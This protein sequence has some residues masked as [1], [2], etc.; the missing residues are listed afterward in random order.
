MTAFTVN[1]AYVGS[2][3]N[4]LY[5]LIAQSVTLKR[6]RLNRD[7]TLITSGIW[8]NTVCAVNRGQNKGIWKDD[9]NRIGQILV[10]G[11]GELKHTVCLSNLQVC[12][13]ITVKRGRSE[14]PRVPI[15][16]YF[17]ITCSMWWA[18]FIYRKMETRVQEEW[19][20][21]E[22]FTAWLEKQP[23]YT[24]SN[25]VHA[26]HQGQNIKKWSF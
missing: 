3:G 19:I 6:Y 8:A 1:I 24:Y 11:Y 20:G 7:P 12:F 10:Q 23:L 4:Y 18:V 17:Y 22:I 9:I 16:L 14:R 15:S 13:A 21:L 25:T 26:V 2:I 5:I